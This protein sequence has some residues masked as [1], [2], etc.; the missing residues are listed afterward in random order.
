M[1]TVLGP[2]ELRSEL[3][4][5]AVAIVWRA[6]DTSLEREVA[7]KEPVMPANADE[8]VATEFAARFVRE[9][10]AAARLNHPGVVTIYNADI[11]DGRPAIVSARG[12]DYQGGL[13][14]AS[15]VL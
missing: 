14:H 9:G 8:T 7:L 4:R 15:W 6:F 12:R 5:A 11:Y 13:V 10:K 2:Y 3:G 1:S